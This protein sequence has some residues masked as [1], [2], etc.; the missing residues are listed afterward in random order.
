MFNNLDLSPRNWKV[1]R[2]AWYLAN[3]AE[4]E[5]SG[6]F[7]FKG[8]KLTLGGQMLYGEADKVSSPDLDDLVNTG[9]LVYYFHSHCD[10]QE[11]YF[12]PPSGRDLAHLLLTNIC[13][14][15]NLPAAVLAPEGVYLY[16]ITAEERDKV[17]R[18]YESLAGS[19]I[20]DNQWYDSLIAKY[21]EYITPCTAKSTHLSGIIDIPDIGIL[22]RVYFNM[23]VILEFSPW[24]DMDI[25]M[26]KY[27]CPVVNLNSDWNNI[28]RSNSP[29]LPTIG[30]LPSPRGAIVAEAVPS[31]QIPTITIS[32]PSSCNSADL[33]SSGTRGEKR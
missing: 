12:Y 27:Y 20:D 2:I 31:Y 9:Q 11:G 8:T 15:R 18:K 21:E 26:G 29:I 5:N 7:Y 24:P 30:P 23:G 33:E 4:Q 6:Y 19:G 14:G 13:Q 22:R 25:H 1:L 28:P 32:N 16:S 10:T 17:A 3:E